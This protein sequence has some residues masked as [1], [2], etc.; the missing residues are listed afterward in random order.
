MLAGT[1]FRTP[2]QASAL[3]PVIGI[4]F[5]ML[6]GC[7]WPLS[8][9]SPAMRAIGHATPQA[10]AVD[11]WTALLSGHGTIAMIWHELGILALFGLGF[12]AIATVR[13]RRLFRT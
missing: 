9:V 1:L 5:A 12:F 6:G 8:I 11:A 2:E 13:A 10:W 4:T 3:G 7:M